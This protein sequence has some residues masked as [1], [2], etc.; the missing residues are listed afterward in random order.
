MKPVT[1]VAVSIW[2]L[3][4]MSSL[5]AQM[6]LQESGA[7]PPVSQVEADVRLT[8]EEALARG[9]ETSHRLAEL[10]ARGDA[11]RAV[12]A[13][14]DAADRPV[15]A[16][17]GGY[18]RTSHVPEFG[19][20]T[21]VVGFQTIYPDVP[22]NYRTRVDLQWPIYTGGRTAALVQAAA[23]EAEATGADLQTAR[24]DLRLEITRAYW[25][26]IT[27]AEAVRVLEEAVAR[28]EAQLTDVRNQLN[29]GLIS[30]AD[31]LSVEAE[32]SRQR[33]LLIEAQNQA[34]IVR[35]DL[36]RLTGLAPDTPFFLASSLSDPTGPPGNLDALIQEA[37]QQRPERLALENRIAA[38]RSRIGAARAGRLPVASVVGGVDY[39]R[40]NP[41]IF[42]RE[43]RWQDFW[44]VGVN[45]NWSIWDGGRVTAEVAE[46]TAEASA[47]VE[48]L[49]EFDEVLDFDVRQRRLDLL[50]RLAS[51]EVA[52]DGVR[53]AAE[54]RRVTAERFAAGVAT[55]T[56]LLEAQEDLLTSELN[57][58]RALAETR[59]A[60][61]R[62]A[63]ALGR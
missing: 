32:R 7:L 9:L 39:A 14:R 63:R 48:R 40:P 24:A 42:P 43:D 55:S 1:I 5:R 8:L 53:S 38:A 4:S 52:A 23:A 28:V 56:E 27:A 29:V 10:K 59:L 18:M 35:A 41:L 58:T 60:E 20:R 33:L 46:A 3:G 25:A 62:L 15:I 16:L 49:A 26:N 2:M 51:I 37:R 50:A 34:E 57:R 45:V 6:I 12:V 36:R 47:T 54:A 11:A 44:D 17:E 21:P 30:P 13:G 19:L 61:A 22:D 31:V